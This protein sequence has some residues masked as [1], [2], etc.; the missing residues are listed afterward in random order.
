MDG[1]ASQ[2]YYRRYHTLKIHFHQ[3]CLL[4]IFKWGEFVEVWGKNGG[5]DF[6]YVIFKWRD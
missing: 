4:V 3:S 6:E 1:G 2:A 5:E